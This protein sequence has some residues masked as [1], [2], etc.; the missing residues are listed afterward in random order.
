[1]IADL[2]RNARW[3]DGVV[4]F[5]VTSFAWLVYETVYLGMPLTAGLLVKVALIWGLASVGYA[6]LS[7][8][9]AERA[10]QR[11]E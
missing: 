9:F 10:K 7:G 1:M 5:V 2:V 8:Y 3:M 4:W 11:K 6:L